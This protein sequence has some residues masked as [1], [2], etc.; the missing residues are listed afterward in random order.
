MFASVVARRLELQQLLPVLATR[1]R[2]ALLVT[3]TSQLM[4]ELDGVHVHMLSLMS[5]LFI[6]FV[7][8]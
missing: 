3:G 2:T 8:L 1:G 6:A 4:Q 5:Y 7:N